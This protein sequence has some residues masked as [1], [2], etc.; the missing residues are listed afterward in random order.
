MKLFSSA[1]LVA[2]LSVGLSTD[3]LY[4]R[5]A[6]GVAQIL[7]KSRAVSAQ[8]YREI[9]MSAQNLAEAELV[10]HASH[11]VD[12][13]LR[14]LLAQTARHYLMFANPQYSSSV[15]D[16][17]AARVGPDSDVLTSS[18]PTFGDVILLADGTEVDL[19]AQDPQPLLEAIAG[20]D[21]IAALENLHRWHQQHLKTLEK[22]AAYRVDFNK[23]VDRR[24]HY[25]FM[26]H[27]K[28]AV[29]L[30]RRA[31]DRILALLGVDPVAW[32]ELP[33]LDLPPRKVSIRGQHASVIYETKDA[34]ADFYYD[35]G[36][37]TQEFL[38]AE[39]A[40]SRSHGVA[41]K[42]EEYLLWKGIDGQLYG[43]KLSSIT[44]DSVKAHDLLSAAV[45]PEYV[46]ELEALYTDYLEEVEQLPLFSK[47]AERTRLWGTD[48]VTMYA[49]RRI[50]F[51]LKG[52][53]VDKLI[54][55]LR[56]TTA[57]AGSSEI[58]QP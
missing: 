52:Y 40:L 31:V 46:A 13:K 10:L 39:Q 47:H 51:K 4:A 56:G 11:R 1:M 38:R 27:D 33:R 8:F 6:Q 58:L 20:Q 19:R 24:P 49:E 41:S 43:G 2:S 22:K 26:L 18:Q 15:L 12:E 44:R 7:N 55:Q 5:A 3:R 30:K 37:L 42:V 9:G 54:A 53:V 29:Q 57:K 36:R 23:F 28:G 25:A 48:Y 21:F 17:A 45:G 50:A 34:S 35:L 16:R 14:H 32:E